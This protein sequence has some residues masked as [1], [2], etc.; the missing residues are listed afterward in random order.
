[1]HGDRSLES[2]YRDLTGDLGNDRRTVQNR[3]AEAANTRITRAT[4]IRLSQRIRVEG[5]AGTLAPGAV[6]RPEG[7]VLLPAV[8]AKRGA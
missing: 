7:N 8:G 5:I 6:Y 3:N 1:M 4:K 2:R